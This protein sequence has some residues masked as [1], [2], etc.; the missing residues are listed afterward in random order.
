LAGPRSEGDLL[1]TVR[2]EVLRGNLQ[3]ARSLADQAIGAFPESLEL[4]RA[5]AGIL[6][7]CGL[8][9]AAEAALRAL[10]ARHPGDAASAFSLARMLREQG[11]TA[12]AAAVLRACFADEANRRDANL[13]ITAIELLDESDR[14]RDAE[15]IAEAAIEANPDDP[16]L[17]AYAGMLAVQTGE[18]E[19]AREHYLFALDHDPR[20]VKWH[21]PIGLAS[22]L[23]YPDPTHPDFAR[24][25][26]GLRRDDLSDLARAELHFA[27]AKACDDIGDYGEAAQN[28][29]SGNAIRKRDAAWSRKAWRRAIEARLAAAPNMP[30]IPPTPDFSPIF[31]VGM[32]RSGTTVLADRLGRLPGVCNRGEPPW[33][34]RLA[35]QPE[36]QG[37]T[38][39]AVLERAAKTYV[40]HV[41]QDDAGDARW[42][43][44]KQPL[45]FRYLDLALAMFPDAKVI[46][47]QRNARDTALSLWMQCFLEDV[48]GYSYDFDDIARVMRDCERLMEHWR[49]RYP[50]SIRT[51]R[52]EDLVAAPDGIVA[53]LTAWIGIPDTAADAVATNHRSDNVIST[54]SLWQARQPIHSRSVNRSEQYLPYIP[55]LSR[56]RG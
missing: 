30:G 27:L 55:E 38:N 4:R 20:A 19:R 56:L 23:R 10:L 41:R 39:G 35:L 7:Q 18:F 3:R 22:T 2:A 48:Q 17:H 29:R 53:E 49:Q 32:P 8:A 21:V 15:A 6:Q 47:C 13:S 24:F 16:R 26:A 45:N 12:A 31:I 42:F 28:L 25:R 37:A 40:A 33:L 52:Y 43:I 51:V 1:A 46:Y 14:K 34:A 50:G 9:E 5:Q 44:D 54:A 11:R 36:L